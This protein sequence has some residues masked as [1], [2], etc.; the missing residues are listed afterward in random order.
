[1][2]WLVQAQS[3]DEKPVLTKV[4]E[5][6]LLT[7][8]VVFSFSPSVVSDE[9]GYDFLVLPFQKLPLRMALIMAA[10]AGRAM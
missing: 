6:D 5:R 8:S 9:M 3:L 4:W 10:A 2:S 1:M 7:S